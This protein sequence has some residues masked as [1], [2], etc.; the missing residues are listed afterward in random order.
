[1]IRFK[2]GCFFSNPFFAIKHDDWQRIGP[3][4]L[5]QKT[6]Q[7]ELQFTSRFPNFQQ[8][9]CCI[10]ES[11]SVMNCNAVSIFQGHQ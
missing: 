6:Q 7:E 1:M 10:F 2:L 11:S 4:K 9:T 5:C 8:L 3:I